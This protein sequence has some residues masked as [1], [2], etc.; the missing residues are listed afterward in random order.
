M[1]FV[2]GLD[3][4]TGERC[5]ILTSNCLKSNN[6]VLA[7]SRDGTL[8]SSRGS[9]ADTDFVR[10]LIG[11][12]SAGLKTHPAKN[13]LHLLVVHYFEKRRLFQLDGQALAERAVKGGVVR[14]VDEI[15]KDDRV[16]VRQFRRATEEKVTAHDK[17]GEKRREKK[18]GGDHP[19]SILFGDWRGFQGPYQFPGGLPASRWVCL[20]TTAH[21]IF[22]PSRWNGFPIRGRARAGQHFIED[23]A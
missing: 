9:F 15:G 6:V 13:A 10:Y 19:D 2:F 11:D 4:L 7:Q 5:A 16:S 8:D 3:L 14:I 12:S 1:L 21:D 17:E 23:T 18:G 20:Q 22:E